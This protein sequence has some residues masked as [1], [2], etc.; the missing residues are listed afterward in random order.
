MQKLVSIE[1]GE[2]ATHYALIGKSGKNITVFKSGAFATPSGTFSSGVISA[3]D[4]LCSAI[5]N[6]LAKSEIKEKRVIFTMP[7]KHI[8]PSVINLPHQSNPK[9]L[10]EL[11][12]SEMQN[13]YT[14]SVDDKVIGYNVTDTRKAIIECTEDAD[15]NLVCNTDDKKQFMSKNKKLESNI[16]AYAIP[17]SYV[18]CYEE[19][20]VKS[21]LKIVDVDCID[22][23]VMQA[24]KEFLT[25]EPSMSVYIG[26]SETLIHIYD[27]KFLVL[28]RRLES[29]YSNITKALNESGIFEKHLNNSEALEIVEKYKINY[30]L[31]KEQLAEVVDDLNTTAEKIVTAGEIIGTY[32]GDIINNVTDRYSGFSKSSGRDIT[33]ISIVCKYLSFPNISYHINEVI[34]Y[35]IASVVHKLDSI[36][37]SAS[38]TDEEIISVFGCIGAAIK[39]LKIRDISSEEKHEIIIG[40]LRRTIIAATVVAVAFIVSSEFISAA[41]YTNDNNKLEIENN[42]AVEAKSLFDTYTK[43]QSAYASMQAIEAMDKTYMNSLYDIITDISKVSPKGTLYSSFNANGQTIVLTLT[44]KDKKQAS[45]LINNLQG[46][47]WFSAVDIDS[48]SDSSGSDGNKVALSIICTLST[49]ENAATTQE[50]TATGETAAT[51]DA[52]DIVTEPGVE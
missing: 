10:K 7:N 3:S 48:I 45:I 33:K 51:Q 20:A 6:A 16:A 42:N 35:E 5:K 11:V 39:P 24:S 18:K 12:E 1:V 50:T 4:D 28:Q 52:D 36:K 40:H 26:S 23:S 41:Y 21:G 8:I 25:N 15:G 46:L 47:Q 19:I 37:K 34:G 14:T 9:I 30:S 49:P 22:N 31:T 38:V 43:Y 32:I 17:E 27:G 29:G 44:I 13:K 2:L